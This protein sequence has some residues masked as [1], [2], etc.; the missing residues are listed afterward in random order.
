MTAPTDAAS[1][2]NRELRAKCKRMHAELHKAHAEIAKLRDE[3][4]WLDVAMTARDGQLALMT[5]R[6]RLLQRL[7]TISKLRAAAAAMPLE[8]AAE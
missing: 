5:H 3:I 6:A 2:R 4:K 8:A 1:Q 7:C